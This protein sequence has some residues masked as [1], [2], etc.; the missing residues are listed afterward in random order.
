MVQAYMFRRKVEKCDAELTE[1]KEKSEMG[2]TE[3]LVRLLD[4]KVC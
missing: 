3:L 4:G 2:V 1:R